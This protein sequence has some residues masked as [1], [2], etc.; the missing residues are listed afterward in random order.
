MKKII[1]LVLSFVLFFMHGCNDSEVNIQSTNLSNIKIDNIIVGEPIKNINFNN[2]TAA[3]RYSGNYK[4]LFD[5]IVIGEDE[6]SNTVNYIF[7]RFDENCTVIS[8]NNNEDLNTIEDIT[9]ILGNN[10]TEKWENREQG[11][12]NRIYYDTMRNIKSEFVYLSYD[13]SLSWIRI[14]KLN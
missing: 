7:S 1:Y 10:Y 13:D 3:E 4:Y 12:K 6:E 14:S 2:Y 9:K 8:I 11:L 5:E